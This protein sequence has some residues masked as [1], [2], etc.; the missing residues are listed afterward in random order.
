MVHCGSG[1]YDEPVEAG[2]IK[3]FG[4]IKLTGWLKRSGF[5]I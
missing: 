1:F 3:L 2:M 5:N 4:V